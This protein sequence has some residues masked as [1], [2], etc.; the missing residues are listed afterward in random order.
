MERDMELTK[1]IVYPVDPDAEEREFIC[2]WSGGGYDV[3]EEMLR[4]AVI[5][6]HI[7]DFQIEDYSPPFD[8]EQFFAYLES[9]RA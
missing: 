1:V 6:G 5:D 2:S 7:T 8:N 4:Q 3:A 9:L